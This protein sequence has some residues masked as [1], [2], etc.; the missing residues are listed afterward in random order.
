LGILGKGANSFGELSTIHGLSAFL[1]ALF[2]CIM[3][4][5][6]AFGNSIGSILKLPVWI[7]SFI[8]T[9]QRKFSTKALGFGI[10]MVSGFL[11]CG[12]LYPAYAASFATGSAA[13]GGLVMVSFFFGTVPALTSLGLVFAKLRQKIPHH[14]ITGFG[15]VLILSSLVL[16][17]YR[18]Y[19]HSH[20]E[21]CVHPI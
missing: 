3:G 2:L 13:V 6:L 15:V 5:R 7:Q 16:L 1:S 8:Q 12:V 14:W 9:I 17:F 4:I 21:N 10:G 18:F 11:P 20:S 19:S